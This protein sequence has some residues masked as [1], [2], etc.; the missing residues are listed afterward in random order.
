[1]R[2]PFYDH[3]HS[4]WFFTTL[5]S[6]LKISAWK[7]LKVDAVVEKASF[8]NICGIFQIMKRVEARGR[9]MATNYTLIWL[10]FA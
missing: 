2:L 7:A 8:F 1:M 9:E 10:H 4:G 5:N 6:I 3:C